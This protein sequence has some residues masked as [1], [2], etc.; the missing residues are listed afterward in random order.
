MHG[1]W[2]ALKIEIWKMRR[3]EGELRRRTRAKGSG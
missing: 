1:S 2:E 3:W